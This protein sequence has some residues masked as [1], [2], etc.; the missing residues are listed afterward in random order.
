M[1]YY[2][3]FLSGPEDGELSTLVLNAMR[4]V[5]AI[6]RPL[7]DNRKSFIADLRDTTRVQSV[8]DTCIFILDVLEGR[9]FVGTKYWRL[10]K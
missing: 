2:T 8:K 5:G 9:R 3:T 7:L 4:A 10:L 6:H 1:E